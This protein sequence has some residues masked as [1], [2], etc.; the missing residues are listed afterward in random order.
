MFIISSYIDNEYG[1]K[2]ENSCT[3]VVK[4]DEQLK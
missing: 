1:N 3:I 4:S 2:N